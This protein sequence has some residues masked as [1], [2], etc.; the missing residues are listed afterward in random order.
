M[1]N[2]PIQNFGRGLDTRRDVLTTQPGALVQLENGHI[3]PGGEIEKRKAFVQYSALIDDSTGDPTRLFGLVGTTNGLTTFVDA[4]GPITVTGLY[5]RRQ[6]LPNG[7]DENLM[8]INDAKVFGGLDWVAAVYSG[9]YTLDYYNNLIVEDFIEGLQY[10][11]D[12]GVP[13][14]VATGY[15]TLVNYYNT[16]NNI[17]Y[18][19]TSVN[20]SSGVIDI[21]GPVG[22]EYTLDITKVSTSGTLVSIVH[23]DPT[24]QVVEVLA[25]GEFQITGGSHNAGV[26]KISSVKV[27]GVE[28]LNAA[29]DWVT[30]NM[31]TAEAIAVSINTKVSSPE[32]TATTNGQRVLISAVAGS[33]SSPNGFSV[34]VKAAGNVTVGQSGIIFTGTTF[35]VD[36]IRAN[37]VNLLTTAYAFPAAPGQLL[38]AYVASLATDINTGT[39]GTHHY[40]AFVSA[41][42]LQ[43]SK[44]TTSDTDPSEDVSVHYSVAGDGG[45]DDT[46]PPNQ[47]PDALAVVI[48]ATDK[49][50]AQKNQGAIVGLV[51]DELTAVASGGTAPYTYQWNVVSVASNSSSRSV[52]FVAVSPTSSSTSINS[53]GGVPNA[54]QITVVVNCVVTDSNNN[55][56]TS[57]QCIIT[58]P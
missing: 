9:G 8:G 23:Q 56:V 45:N 35:T 7:I 54:I 30:D 17:T 41:N 10:Y 55:T 11:S 3:N 5:V 48:T 31:T 49:F 50:I 12:T 52:T 6:P 15:G 46:N 38:S 33:G 43:I 37:G 34:V 53:T 42:I 51:S 39:V 57:N 21:S 28:T 29:V 20:S 13:A 14:N 44:E 40:I 47:Q 16:Q 58:Y 26:N 25:V 27:N 19:Y 32:Y 36:T 18:P 1:A 4:D 2:F 22:Q 24:A